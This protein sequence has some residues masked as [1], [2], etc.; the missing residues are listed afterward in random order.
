MAINFKSKKDIGPRINEQITASDVRLISSNGKQ[1]WENK[2]GNPRGFNPVYIHDEAWGVRATNDGGCII[3][4]GTGDEYDNYSVVC[5]NSG[6]NSDTWSVYLV[7][8]DV[9]G[10]I[11]WENT[12]GANE[13]DWAGEDLKITNNG[14]IIIG[15]DN[16]QFGF[17]KTKGF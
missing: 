10:N 7:R 13:E 11:I 17:L 2:V 6:E 3:V 9:N 5:E 8:Y 15:V 14:D 4:A 12:F 16:G 1:L